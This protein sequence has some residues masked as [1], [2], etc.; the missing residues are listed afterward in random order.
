M[1]KRMGFQGIA[2]YGAAGSTAST[3][4]TNSRDITYSLTT[5]KGNTTVRGDGSA[6]PIHYESVTERIT[7]I[8]IQMVNE[9]TDAAL[10]AMRVAAFAGNPIAIRLKDHSSGKG[11][12]GDV[13]LEE[14]EP[15]PLNGEQVI[16][17]TCT[18]NNNSRSASL[19]V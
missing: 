5:S 7:S 4:L 8:T 10:E 2:Y 12:D 19:Y 14:S 11:F 3:Q 6:P 18:P 17:F 16:D 13:I 9:S 1:A 15:Y